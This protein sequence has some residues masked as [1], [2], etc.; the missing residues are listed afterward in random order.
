MNKRPV[1]LFGFARS[2][3]STLRKILEAPPGIRVAHE[4]FNPNGGKR[5]NQGTGARMKKPGEIKDAHLLFQALD[6]LYAENVGIKHL[7]YQLSE[8]LTRDLLR[9]R[10]PRVIFLYRRNLLQRIIS[11]MISKRIN[12]WNTDRKK[13]LSH[14][15]S[16]FDLEQIQNQ[17]AYDQ[18]RIQVFRAMVHE[19]VDE[20]LEVAYEDLYGLARSEEEKLA[21]I[22]TLF[23]F[24]FAQRTVVESPDVWARIKALLDPQESKLN[25]THSYRRIPNAREIDRKLGSEETG[26]LFDA[27]ANVLTRRQE[28]AER[29]PAWFSREIWR[30]KIKWGIQ[31]SYWFLF[32][33]QT[34]PIRIFFTHHKCGTVWSQRVLKRVVAKADTPSSIMKIKN[35]SLPLMAAARKNALLFCS[36]YKKDRQE[37]LGQSGMTYRAVHIRRDPRDMIVSGYFSHRYS[38]E[39][40]N[41]WGRKF[42]R[43]H[44]DWLNQVSFEEGLA[45]EINRGYALNALSTWDFN[46]L[47]ERP[48]LE[49]RFEDLVG[50]ESR[51]V[52]QQIVNFLAIELPANQLG[53]ILDK[54]SFR[55]L[56]GRDPGTEDVNS[57]FR[58]G[59][60]G[61]W[62]NHFT[63]EHVQQF[64]DKWGDLLIRLGYEKDDTWG[65]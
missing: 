37:E 19:E 23:A 33:Q 35:E 10:S 31:K 27:Q 25:G 13:V 39:V 45:W 64:K 20:V 6:A 60:P 49:V 56:A 34:E 29:V 50:P 44:R 9:Y 12:H 28:W 5:K 53:R 2:G 21:Q 24:A 55:R 11:S 65:V 48:I 52:F 59:T 22:R 4:P 38:H 26:Y 63:P 54:L 58:K 30:P 61:D 62:R 42:L 18:Q 36:S 15:F 32:H 47:D 41:E 16:A 7:A 51:V 43:A 40:N 17:L 8:P 57:H 3:S 46:E 1:I 14:S